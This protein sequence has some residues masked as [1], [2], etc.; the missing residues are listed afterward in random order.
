MPRSNRSGTRSSRPEARGAP[1]RRRPARIATIGPG[2]RRETFGHRTSTRRDPAAT[3]TVGREA[4]ALCAPYACHFARNSHRHRAHLEAQQ[5]L[6]LRREDD[7]RDAAREARHDRVR[8]E[9]DRASEPRQAERDEDQ[10]GENRADRQAFD[11][12][13]GDD[14][15]HDDDEGARRPADLDA[16]A[17]EER[18]QESRDDGGDEPLLRRHAGGDREGE[19]ERNR[20]DADDDAGLQIREKL[21]P[22]V[23]AQDDERLG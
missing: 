13:A 16:A 12:V 19:S 18:D 4:D 10:A 23:A 21:R 2:I 5:I 14:P 20:D 17:S 15:V 7:D 9:L 11:P 8:D 1:R 6:D 22:R 3:A